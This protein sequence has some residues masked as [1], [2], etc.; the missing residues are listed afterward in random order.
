M[1]SDNIG[2][3]H[4]YL[5]AL[6]AG[7]Q[8]L[9]TRLNTI[10]KLSASRSSDAAYKEHV[11][12]TLQRV[13]QI[14]KD[15]WEGD[16]KDMHS[17]EDGEVQF[18]LHAADELKRMYVENAKQGFEIREKLDT[19]LLHHDYFL[20]LG[21]CAEQAY[22]REHFVKGLV[23]YGEVFRI[24]EVADRWR[25]HLLSCQQEIAHVNK[26]FHILSHGSLSE[27]ELLELRAMHEFIPFTNRTKSID[28]T[29]LDS[30]RMKSDKPEIFNFSEETFQPWAAMGL[31]II[32]ASYWRAYSFTA[33]VAL[34]WLAAGF[35]DPALAAGYYVRGIDVELALAWIGLGVQGASAA[36]Y[37]EQGIYPENYETQIQ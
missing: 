28:I 30:I 5:N 37:Q 10:E 7:L 27:D 13:I 32:G 18:L 17:S 4:G 15:F 12:T 16:R 20:M 22:G 11:T 9:Y 36:V 29:V 26:F 35:R 31:D 14:Y 25:N 8:G 34:Y 6:Y 33:D 21:Q 2:L 1:D 23:Q 24:A 3:Q 19:E